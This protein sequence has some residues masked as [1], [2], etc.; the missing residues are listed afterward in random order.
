M[1]SLKISL[2]VG[3]ASAEERAVMHAGRTR[4]PAISIARV[5]HLLGV[6]RASYDRHKEVNKTGREEPALGAAIEQIALEIPAYD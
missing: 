1:G 3:G 5:R 4:F 6:S 2:A